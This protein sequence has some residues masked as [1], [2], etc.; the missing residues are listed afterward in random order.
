MKAIYLD[1]FAGISGNMLLG[2]FLQA[3]L[4]EKHLKEELLKL[5]PPGEAELEVSDVSKNGIR[6]KYVEVRVCGEPAEF[7]PVDAQ[8]HH[9]HAHEHEHTFTHTHDGTTHTHTVTHSHD[10]NHYVTDDRHGHH[11]TNE[12]LESLPGAMHI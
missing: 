10:H 8:A 4:P 2:A 12:E 3:G 7:R 5:L 6:A 1:C 9:A 11:H